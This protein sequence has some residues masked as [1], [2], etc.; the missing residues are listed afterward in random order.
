MRKDNKIGGIIKTRSGELSFPAD[1][2]AD[3][4]ISERNATP[5]MI[6]GLYM[7]SIITH[8][9]LTTEGVNKYGTI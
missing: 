3:H 5:N 4:K 6:T 2:I 1:V 9:K 8:F 7:D